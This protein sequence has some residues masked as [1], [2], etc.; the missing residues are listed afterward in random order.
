M[1]QTSGHARIGK[2]HK[3][4]LNTATWPTSFDGSQCTHVGVSAM[5]YE[6]FS[7]SLAISQQQCG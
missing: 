3:I 6:M 2:E 4:P 1:S 7:T 5:V